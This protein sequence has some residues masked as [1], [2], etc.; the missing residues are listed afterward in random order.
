[1]RFS[2]NILFFLGAFLL[3]LPWGRA[4]QA[5][6]F[7]DPSDPTVIR[8]TEIPFVSEV[9][10]SAADLPTQSIS[11][12]KILFG[13]QRFSYLKVSPDGRVLAFSVDG[14][15]SDWSGLYE[16][17]SKKITEA[18]LSFDSE[19]LSPYWSS[20]GRHVAFECGEAAGRRVL[21]IY[22]VEQATLCTLDGR[23]A[24]NK[25]FNFYHPFWSESG[26][27]LYFQVEVNNAYRRSMGLKPLTAATRIGEI[28]TQCQNLV[29]RSVEKFM[30]EVPRL[31]LPPE[32]TALLP[33]EPL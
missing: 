33:R 24:K 28:G 14:D 8:R 11:H 5:A 7:I 13:R 32:A 30:A 9:L 17:K 22:D 2:Q 18:S 29:L 25:Y 6:I 19:A 16:L 10:L 12:P 20:D 1:M 23:S 15:S 21:R 31:S 3:A 4:D 27:K 26:E